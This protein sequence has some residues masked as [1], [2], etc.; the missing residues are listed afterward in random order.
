MPNVRDVSGRL[1][2]IIAGRSER[3]QILLQF[4]A[5]RKLWV[6]HRICSLAF[7]ADDPNDADA[8]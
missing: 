6:N 8:L 5:R 2:S 3:A 4:S 1:V 7:A